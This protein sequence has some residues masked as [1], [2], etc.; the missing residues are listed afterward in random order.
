MNGIMNEY[1]I[2][3]VKEYEFDK[4]LIHKIDST[5]DNFYRDCLNKYY[6]TFDKK[7]DYDIQLTNIRN[8]EIISVTNF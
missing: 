4:P 7:C 5:I 6:H 1:Q 8:N 3:I 2:T